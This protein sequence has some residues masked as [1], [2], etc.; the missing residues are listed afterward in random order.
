MF[1]H[2]FETCASCQVEFGL[3]V[4]P[5]RGGKG[6]VGDRF[7]VVGSRFQRHLEF[8]GPRVVKTTLKSLRLLY[9]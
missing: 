8:L 7:P 2:G 6:V 3:K 9:V 4:L 5:Y 1:V